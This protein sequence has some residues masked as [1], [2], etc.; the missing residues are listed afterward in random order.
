[1]LLVATNRR[2]VESGK[3]NATKSGGEKAL[4]GLPTLSQQ[5]SQ[6]RVVTRLFGYFANELA[7]QDSVMLVKH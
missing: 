7:V 5:D 4:Q 6:R 3:A 1:M 2:L